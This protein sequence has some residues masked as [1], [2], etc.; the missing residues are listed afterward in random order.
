LSGGD[1]SRAVALAGMMAIVSG[2]VCILAGVARL[3]F[4]TDLLSKP[5]RYG[6]MNGI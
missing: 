6:Y 4:V 3:G 1:P 5:I 2:L